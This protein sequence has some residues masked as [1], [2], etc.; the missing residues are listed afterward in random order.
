LLPQDRVTVKNNGLIR[1]LLD[2]ANRDQTP[3]QVLTL[4]AAFA[5]RGG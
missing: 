4:L 3:D 1:M 2:Q 5:P